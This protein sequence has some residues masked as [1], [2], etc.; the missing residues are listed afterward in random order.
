[1]TRRKGEIT[2]RRRD[3]T[4]PFQVE[5]VVPGTGL[6]AA[7][8]IMYRW[9]ALHD[10]ETKSGQRSMTWCFCR[11]EIADAFATD[12]GG[13]RIDLPVDTSALRVDRPD[14]AELERRH[15]AARFGIEVTTGGREI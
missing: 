12:F 3:L 7:H 1:M 11:R 8:A 4:H 10:H 5:I 15:R 9:A 14:A 6:G 2:N 13:L